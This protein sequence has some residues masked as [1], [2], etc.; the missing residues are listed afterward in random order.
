M[1]ILHGQT[2]TPAEAD[3]AIYL[4]FEGRQDEPPGAARLALRRGPE[5]AEP[6]QAVLRHDI[7]D[8]DLAP[9]ADRVPVTPITFTEYRTEARSLRATLSDLV[10]RARA[11]DR[12]LVSWSRHELNAVLADASPPDHEREELQLRFRDGKETAKRWL[13]AELP[14]HRFE[15]DERKRRNTL[16][17]YLDLTGYELPDDFVGGTVG[18]GIKQVRRGLAGGDGTWDGL[19]DSQKKAWWRILGHNLHDCLGLRHVVRLAAHD[20]ASASSA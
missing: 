17:R 8:E 15:P 5:A 20:L 6:R 2:I 16:A 10:G 9:L 7:L 14:D 18:P 19:T 13:R 3:N 4:D 1:A 12:L 11:Q